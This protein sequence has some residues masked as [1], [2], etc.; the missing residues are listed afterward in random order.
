MTTA[1]PRLGIN[2]M[3]WSGQVSPAELDLLPRIAALGYD[4]VEVPVLAPGAGNRLTITMRRYANP[5][6]F[7]FPWP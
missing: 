7:A 2:L 5:P 3:A 6:T 4:G 1:T